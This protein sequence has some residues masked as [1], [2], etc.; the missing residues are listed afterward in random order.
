MPSSDGKPLPRQ[1]AERRVPPLGLTSCSR[2]DRP[3]SLTVNVAPCPHQRFRDD[4]PTVQLD[5]MADDCQAEPKTAV[6]SGRA[7]LGLLKSLEEMRQELGGHPCPV[8]LTAISTC[9]FTR[10]RVI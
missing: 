7:R 9:E 8:S 4:R 10:S 2:E 3:G 5:D 6:G 1:W